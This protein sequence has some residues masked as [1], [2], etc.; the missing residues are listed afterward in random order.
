[1][2][3]Y[4]Q[5]L[6]HS[7]Q[8]GAR[9]FDFGR[10]SPGSGTHQFKR[11]WGATERPLH[12]EYVLLTRTSAPD[13]G[14]QNPRF[15]LLIESWKRLPVWVANRLGPGIVRNIPLK[16]ELMTFKGIRNTRASDH[17]DMVRGVA[18]LVVLI[19]HVRYRFF[20]DY[21]DV[22]EPTALARG[23]YI[24]TAFG[25]DAVMVFFVVSGFLVGSAALRDIRE[26]RWSWAN[27]YTARCV[28][29]YVVLIPGLLLTLFWDTLGLTL[30]SEHPIYTGAPQ[31][32]INDFFNVPARLGAQALVTNTLFLQG[33]FGP[34]FGSNDALW[35]LTYEF[36]YYVAFPFIA[37][38]LIGAVSPLKR[39]TALIAG[40]GLLLL[41]GA[42]IASAFTLWLLGAAVG[43]SPLSRT[44]SRRPVVWSIVT[45]MAF[46]LWLG[47]SH[48]ARVRQLL[49]GSLFVVDAGT[50]VVFSCWLYAFLHDRRNADQGSYGQLARG[51]AGMSYTLYL[52][53]LPLL[54][55]LRAWLVPDRPWSVTRTSIFGACAITAM[56]IVYAY[57]VARLTEHQTPRIKRVLD[58]WRGVRQSATPTSV[59]AGSHL[60]VANETFR[61]APTP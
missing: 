46:V 20:L 53:H 60:A 10:S 22:P 8:Q 27:Y 29:L 42:S 25:H 2:L 31:A 36:W 49:G 50:A 59:L 4:W 41:T 58:R 61:Q 6:E 16:H 48:T 52:V 34:R 47:L 35:S 43:A 30:F 3:L 19:F 37:I 23:W 13:Q 40:I 39:L 21:A 9:T 7:V 44:V 28:R 11:Q 54:V 38:A 51:L 18:A 14:P 1:M 15:S 33:I 45:G 32:Y 12:W 56:A 55:F 24:A 17:L 57:V 5:M 26:G